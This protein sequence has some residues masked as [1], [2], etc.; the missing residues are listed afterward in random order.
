M[1]F[2]KELFGV[3]GVLAALLLL[4]VIQVALPF[5]ILLLLIGIILYGVYKALQCCL[6]GKDSGDVVS[7]KDPDKLSPKSDDLWG[8]IG[9]DDSG[10]EG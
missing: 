6:S 8:D 2:L 5:F 1:G 10:D 7:A 4:V 9:W 3:V